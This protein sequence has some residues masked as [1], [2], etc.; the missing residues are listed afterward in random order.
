MKKTLTFLSAAL[1]G[2]GIFTAQAQSGGHSAGGPGFD[3]AFSKLFGDN[4]AFTAA[5][6]FQTTAPSTG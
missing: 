6:E 1:L 4:Q 3:A 2:M 5:L